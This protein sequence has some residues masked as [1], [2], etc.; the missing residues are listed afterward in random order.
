[1]PVYEYLCRTCEKHF[2]K[3]LPMASSGILVDCPD[4][5]EDSVKSFSMFA[6]NIKKDLGRASSQV[7]CCGGSCGCG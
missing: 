3:R 6:A 2:E 7:G 4:C 1:M 5:G